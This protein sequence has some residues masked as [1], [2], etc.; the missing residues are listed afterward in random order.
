MVLTETTIGQIQPLAQRKNR[1]KTN[2]HLHLSRPAP[3]SSIANFEYYPLLS[4]REHLHFDFII[5]F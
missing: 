5:Y 3:S 1:A 4:K 2:R